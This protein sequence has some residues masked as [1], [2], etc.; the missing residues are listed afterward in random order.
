MISWDNSTNSPDVNLTDGRSYISAV[1]EL[2]VNASETCDG[3][4]KSDMG[5]ARMDI[6]DSEMGYLGFLDSESYGL[7]WKVRGARNAGMVCGGS[8]LPKDFK[9]VLLYLFI[10]ICGCVRQHFISLQKHT[11]W[12]IHVTILNFSNTVRTSGTN[13]LRPLK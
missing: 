13:S 9:L 10:F 2:I 6:E 5:E 8:G 11:N 1:S 12:F 7:T 4:A 3:R